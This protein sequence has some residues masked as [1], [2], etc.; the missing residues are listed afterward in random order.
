MFKVDNK[1]TLS[2]LNIFSPSFS[3]SIVSFEDAFVIWEGKQDKG[4]H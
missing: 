4:F 1:D 3:I 2:T